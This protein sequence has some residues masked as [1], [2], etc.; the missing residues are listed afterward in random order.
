M[1]LARQELDKQKAA[2]LEQEL[3]REAKLEQELKRKAELEQELKREVALEQ[4]LKKEADVQENFKPVTA[5]EV[6][7]E[8]ESL[9]KLIT[10]KFETSEGSDFQSKAEGRVKNLAGKFF[11]VEIGILE[12]SLTNATTLAKEKK[13]LTYVAGEGDE[14]VLDN[15]KKLEEEFNKR[16]GK[17]KSL[18]EEFSDQEKSVNY[19]ERKANILAS[20]FKKTIHIREKAEERENEKVKSLIQDENLKSLHDSERSA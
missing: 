12:Q 17:L 3:K 19:F 2:E 15:T 13:K 16:E 4:K 6:K 9:N 20:S 1:K 18:E 11:K 10:E 14:E 5:A 7:Q 8:V